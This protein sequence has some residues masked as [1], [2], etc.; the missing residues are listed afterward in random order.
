MLFDH[1]RQDLDPGPVFVR[2]LWVMGHGMLKSRQTPVFIGKD[3]WS[4]DWSDV[5]L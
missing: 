1:E 3:G 5:E 2:G 4:L